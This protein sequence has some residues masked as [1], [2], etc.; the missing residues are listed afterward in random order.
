MAKFRERFEAEHYLVLALETAEDFIA[1]SGPGWHMPRKDL[2]PP[3][4]CLVTD[5]HADL[6]QLLDTICADCSSPSSPIDIFDDQEQDINPSQAFPVRVSGQPA[7]SRCSR[8]PS[9]VE[10]TL[11]PAPQ[12]IN[13]DRDEDVRDPSDLEYDG[14]ASDNEMETGRGTDNSNPPSPIEEDAQRSLPSPVQP[15]SRPSKKWLC[16]D[17]ADTPSPSPPPA[18]A[19]ASFNSDRDDVLDVP[20]LYAGGE[21][22][23]DGMEIDPDADG[24]KP[25]NPIDV[26]SWKPP[27]G[28]RS[29]A[30]RGRQR[31]GVRSAVAGTSL[32]E[33]RRRPLSRSPTNVGNDEDVGDASASEND[34]EAANDGMETDPDA[35]EW[36]PDTQSPPNM[37][38]IRKKLSK[39]RKQGRETRHVDRYVESMY[40]EFLN[41]GVPGDIKA[42][43]IHAALE[44]TYPDLKL[45][46]DTVRKE[47]RK[48]R[49]LS[50]RGY[51]GERNSYRKMRPIKREAEG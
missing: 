41:D 15:S 5:D 37:K 28:E 43:D 9:V 51:K 6:K 39:K 35:E 10:G 31:S 13:S 20:D 38:A 33:R 14:E 8:V 42:S 11:S 27:L 32:S 22:S 4:Y 34:G 1:A 7:E 12:S 50:Y 16:S 17:I 18:R 44:F 19:R 49:G 23:N 3:E 47:M 40:R 2:L 46:P 29:T 24:S 21:E 36:G 48:I 30:R 25:S 45:H 26:D